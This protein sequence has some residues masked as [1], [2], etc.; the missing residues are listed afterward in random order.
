MNHL[1]GSRR[2]SVC[3]PVQRGE[4]FVAGRVDIGAGREQEPNGFGISAKRGAMKRGQ[5]AAAAAARACFKIACVRI[6]AVPEQSRNNPRIPAR[7]RMMQ[8]GPVITVPRVRLRAGGKEQGDAFFPIERNRQV[9]G[10]EIVRAGFIQIGTGL[11]MLPNQGGAAPDY[12]IV[13][14]C[15]G[16]APGSKQKQPDE[17][18]TSPLATAEDTATKGARTTTATRGKLSLP[19]F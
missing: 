11:H 13:Q 7:R 9:Q 4:P 18:K 10:P 14:G 15:G 16:G 19:A 5:S 12:G 17:N 6:G 1:H 2:V 3:S 8:R